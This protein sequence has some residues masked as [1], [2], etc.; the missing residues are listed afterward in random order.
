MKKC[1]NMHIEITENTWKTEDKRH[2]LKRSRRNVINTSRRYLGKNWIATKGG[3]PYPHNE[4]GQ[5]MFLVFIAVSVAIEKNLFTFS[6]TTI[7]K[8]SFTS[9]KVEFLHDSSA[10]NDCKNWLKNTLENIWYSVHRNVQFQWLQKKKRFHQFSY[11]ILSPENK[12]RRHN[13]RN[14]WESTVTTHQKVS[15]KL[16]A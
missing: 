9:G 8:C 6:T 16:T 12:I 15:T 11:I 1:A 14:E 5:S 3:P 13:D 2:K 4:R 10:K 7:H